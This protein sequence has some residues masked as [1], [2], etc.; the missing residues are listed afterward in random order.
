MCDLC[1]NGNRRYGDNGRQPGDTGAKISHYE[2]VLFKKS[3]IGFFSGVFYHSKIFHVVHDPCL[4]MV[5]DAIHRKT[6]HRGILYTLTLRSQ[7]TEA[8]STL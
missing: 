3:H 1:I 2:L 6:T 4:N 7:H 8:Y 5:M